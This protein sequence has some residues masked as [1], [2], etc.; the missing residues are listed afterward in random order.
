MADPA[1]LI[2]TARQLAA[3]PKRG[4]PKQS[5]LRRAVSTSYYAIFHSI[6]A[7]H[8]D[9]VL[10]KT[11]PKNE[12]FRLTY[13]TIN[14]RELKDVCI[15]VGKSTL[16]DRYKEITGLDKFTRRLQDF[17]SAV[18]NLQE[19]RHTAD[20][21]PLERLRLSQVKT[22]IDLAEQQILSFEGLPNN[23]L[24]QKKL[25]LALVIFP[26]GRRR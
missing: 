5:N 3:A 2:A 6:A 15:E 16:T 13:R 10:G 22:S 19:E 7:A 12:L 1:G 8:T 26:S 23:I 25:F 11:A 9:M 17:S 4:A 24:A 18:V 14:H 21:D 20:Y